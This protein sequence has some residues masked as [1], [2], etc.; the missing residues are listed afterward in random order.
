LYGSRPLLLNAPLESA[1]EWLVADNVSKADVIIANQGAWLDELGRNQNVAFFERF[2]SAIERCFAKIDTLLIWRSTVSAERDNAALKVIANT[3]HSRRW[4][5]LDISRLV[6]TYASNTTA[7]SLKWDSHHP[8]TFFYEEMF[9]LL[10]GY[11]LNS[12]CKMMACE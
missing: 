1:F 7:G 10:F 4:R 2:V 5:T 12:S 3:T 6:S 8:R 9:R 11:L